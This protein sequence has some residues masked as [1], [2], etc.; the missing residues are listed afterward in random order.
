M[1]LE[2]NNYRW[3]AFDESKNKTLL[4]IKKI[5]H[6]DAEYDDEPYLEGNTL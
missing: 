1:S 5:S 3:L 6:P 2:E 4:S